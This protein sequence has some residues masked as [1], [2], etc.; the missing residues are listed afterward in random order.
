MRA[1]GGGVKPSEGLSD[2]LVAPGGAPH[3]DFNDIGAEIVGLG[4]P[5]S[6]VFPG[7]FILSSMSAGLNTGGVNSAFPPNRTPP[8]VALASPSQ[9]M[10]SLLVFFSHTPISPTASLGSADK[11]TWPPPVCNRQKN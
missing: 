6:R 1:S 2:A 8:K 11:Y 4:A 10:L 3:I 7:L 5:G 9:S